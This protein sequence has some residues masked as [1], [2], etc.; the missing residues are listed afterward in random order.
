MTIENSTTRTLTIVDKS[1]RTLTGA[2][3]NLVKAAD[4]L[5]TLSEVSSQLATDIEFKQSS[6][7]ALDQEY[8]HKLRN[9]EA[10][11]KLA[12][13]EKREATLVEV[14]TE[15]GKVAIDRTELNTLKADLIKAQKETDVL[16]EQEVQKALKDLQTQSA[17]ILQQVKSDHSVA[18]AQ[19]QA[20]ATSKDERIASLTEQ[21]KSLLSEIQAERTARV[22]IARAQGTV[23]RQT[24]PTA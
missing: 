24:A 23:H 11:F 16:I 20:Q 2:V 6:L 1:T 8:D 21:N 4:E 22:E 18:L 15:A 3:A 17:S 14:L 9:A 12:L 19:Y 7:T 5:K 10:D 13:K